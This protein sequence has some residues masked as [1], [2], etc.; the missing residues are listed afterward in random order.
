MRAG[1]VKTWLDQGPVILM[2]QCDVEGESIAI[3]EVDDVTPTTEKG[4]LIHLLLT[5]EI[6]T[7]HEDT[8]HDGEIDV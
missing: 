6:L 7:V 8:L 5:G 2:S 3:E 4:W 1:Q